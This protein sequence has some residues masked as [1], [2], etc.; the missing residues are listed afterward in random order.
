MGPIRAIVIVI[1][2][3]GDIIVMPSLVCL[4]CGCWK[5][6]H[7]PRSGQHDRYFEL[8]GARVSVSRSVAIVDIRRR[9]CGVYRR[10][11]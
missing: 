11:R 3:D 8:P 2:L 10:R 9:P 4:L 6:S 7:L 5:R 1:E